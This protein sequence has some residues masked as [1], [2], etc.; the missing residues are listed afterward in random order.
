MIQISFSNGAVILTADDRKNR[1]NL[2]KLYLE[3]CEPEQRE[4]ICA[5]LEEEYARRMDQ[6]RE[7]EHN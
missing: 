5:A 1:L 3:N 2:F 4:E 6:R 7:A